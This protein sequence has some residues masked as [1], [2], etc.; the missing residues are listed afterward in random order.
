MSAA[1]YDEYGIWVNAVLY[2]AVPIGTSILRAIPTAAHT[3]QDVAIFLKALVS[4]KDRYSPPPEQE[5]RAT[6]ER[7]SASPPG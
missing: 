1:L 2:P 5:S 3:P 6:H 7:E 4:I